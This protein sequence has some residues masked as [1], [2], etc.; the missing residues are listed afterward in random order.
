MTL[1]ELASLHS[2][3]GPPPPLLCGGPGW[4]R[5]VGAQASVAEAKKHAPAANAW[6][7]WPLRSLMTV[8][9]MLA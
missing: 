8:E 3:L 7:N 6:S 5:P 2:Q 9:G 4:L 1:L